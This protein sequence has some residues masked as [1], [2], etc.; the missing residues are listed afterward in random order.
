MLTLD[1]PNE[2]EKRLLVLAMHTGRTVQFCAR[3]AI[4]DYIDEIEERYLAIDR[5]RENGADEPY[6]LP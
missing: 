5:I 2:I 4:L 6:D 3:E 1:L